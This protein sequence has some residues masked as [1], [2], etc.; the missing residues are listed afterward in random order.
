MRTFATAA[1][2]VAVLAL[3]ASVSNAQ[4]QPGGRGGMGGAL[5]GPMLLLNKSVEDE[6]KLT[7]AQKDEVKKIQ[8][9]RTEDMRKAF[10][11]S[12]MDKEKMQEA[13][14]AVTESTT[15]AVNKVV[16]G[17]KPEQQKRF[18]QIQVQVKG[19]RAFADEDVAKALKLTD[20]QKEEAKTAAD[21]LAKDSR[22]LLT[23]AGRDRDKRAEAQ[24]KIT[25]LTAKATDKILG[26]LNDEQKKTYKELT[27]EKFEYKPDAPMGGG[28]GGKGGKTDKSF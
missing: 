19:L 2:S 27:G 21:E 22:D 8:D 28:K 12:G 14:K 25:E 3:C 26:G 5:E 17:L 16:E 23:D 18:K 1:L 20:K 10:Q 13:M 24:K 9:K 7:D 15:K 6:L 11:D 4:R